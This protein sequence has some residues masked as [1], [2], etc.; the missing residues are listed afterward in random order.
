MAVVR[1]LI[2]TG[3]NNLKEMTDAQVT[4][5]QTRVRYLY[6]LN[7]SV[8]LGVVGS[9]GSLAAITDTRKKSGT[10]ATSVS[11][12]PSEATT[13]EPQTVTV[14][15]QKANETQADTDVTLDTANK[16][17]P[18][19]YNGSSIQ[20][21]SLQDLRDTFIF[22]AIDT[23]TGA[24]GQPGMHR[25]HTALTLTDYTL[26]NAVPIF[27]DTRANVG[28]YLA[29]NI[30]TSGTTQDI[31]TTVTNYYLF[32]KDNIDPAP[33]HEP[34]IQIRD[35]NNLKQ[36]AAVDIDAILQNEVR[37][38]ASEVAETSIRYSFGDTA[39]SGTNLGTGMSNT[40]LNG[41]GNHQTRYVNTNDYRAQEFP[42]GSAVTTATTFLKVNQI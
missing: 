4:A 7:P 21:M 27:A 16:R 5:V 19:Y 42:N 40:I 30:G 26:V 37:H 20:A 36:F 14:N 23:L 11:S 32:T 8:T 34:L 24:V 38:C 29:G 25:V 3:D 39:D 12:F 2:L 6:A 18:V 1:P 22:P 10:S 41:A 31:P 13:G 35:D 33:T 15:Y 17:F 9:G 28:A